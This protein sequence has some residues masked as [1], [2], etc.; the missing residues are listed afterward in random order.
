MSSI[1]WPQDDV[2]VEYDGAEYLLLG[3]DGEREHPNSPCIVTPAVQ[4]EMDAALSRLYRF[5][6]VLGYFKRGYVDITGRVWG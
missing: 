6:S 4:N 1:A 3:V 2:W 5:A